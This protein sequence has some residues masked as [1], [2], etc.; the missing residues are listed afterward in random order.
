[1]LEWEQQEGYAKEDLHGVVVTPAAAD[2]DG[3]GL[4]EIAFGSFDRRFY[5]LESDGTVR[6]YY[7]AADTVYSSARFV[8]LDDDPPLEVVVASDVTLGP[9]DGGG[10][11][12][13]FDTGPRY[14]KK[15]DFG[16]GFIW[17]TPNLGQVP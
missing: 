13:A 2:T 9:H 5:L 1:T 15:I 16:T 6:W 12:Q 14:P 3:D 17:R 11:L 4:M 10:Y 7:V 8:Q